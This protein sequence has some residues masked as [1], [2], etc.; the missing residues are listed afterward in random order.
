MDREVT[1]ALAQIYAWTGETDEAFR[2]LDHLLSV[3]N[4]LA[5]PISSSIQPGIRCAK[6]LG[7]KR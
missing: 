6:I 7:S 2:L 3:P 5:V 4:G 1:A